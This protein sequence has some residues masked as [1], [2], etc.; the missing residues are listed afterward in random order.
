MTF[1]K[2]L[3][4]AATALSG[5]SALQIPQVPLDAARVPSWSSS[6]GD[7][8]SGSSLPIVDSK[9]L[10][11]LISADNLEARAK[12]FYK[13]AKLG[14]AEYGHPTRVIGSEGTFCDANSPDEAVQLV[15]LYGWR[16]NS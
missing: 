2:G 15:V 3:L 8:S 14:E 16:I 4:V 5:V 1:S 11:G 7:G 13:I 10:Q 12:E 9:A 6:S